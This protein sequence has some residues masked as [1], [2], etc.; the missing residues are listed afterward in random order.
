MTP[1]EIIILAYC[2]LASL[3]LGWAADDIRNRIRKLERPEKRTEAI[4]FKETK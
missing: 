2:V 3:V 4:G 1:G